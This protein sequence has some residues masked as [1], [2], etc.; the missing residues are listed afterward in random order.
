[1][2]FMQRA[3]HSRVTWLGHAT[4]VIDLNGQR[5]ITDPIFSDRA[6][7]FS[8]AGPER[9]QPLP[10]EPSQLLRFDTVVISHNHYDH[11]DEAT[12]KRLTKQACGAPPFSVPFAL[13]PWF[14]EQGIAASQVIELGWWESHHNQGIT[15]T[16]P[17]SQQWS[18]RSLF[19]RMQSLWAS[20]HIE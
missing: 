12:I 20:W 13:K 18:A 2:H 11:L 4:F 9:L 6:S 7:P 3:L 19:D 10:I 1:Q 14:V 8:F 16:A 5:I 17:P 15:Y